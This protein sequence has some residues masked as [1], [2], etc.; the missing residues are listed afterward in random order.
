MNLNKWMILALMLTLTGCT[1]EKSNEPF[2]DLFN[3]T[4]LEGWHILGGKATYEVKDGT[5]VG[6]SVLNTSNTF[7]CSDKLYSDFILE[8]EYKVDPKLNSGIQIRTNSIPEYKNGRVH[9][10]QIEIDPSDRAWSAGIYEEGRRGWLNNLLEN[11]N[12]QKAFKQNDWNLYRIEAVGDTL[13]TWINGVPAAHL[14]DDMT[15]KGFIGLQVHGIGKSKEKEG[16]QVSWRAVRIITEEVEKYTTP[17]PVKAKIT[18]NQLLDG[19]KDKGW[20]MMWDGESTAGWRGAKLDHFPKSGWKIE[21]GALTVLASGGGES[22]AGGDIVSMEKY[23]NFE[24]KLDFKITE[25]ANSGIKY[26]VNTDLNQGKGSSIGLEFQILDD[27]KHPR[28][29]MI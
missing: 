8:V 21:N 26:Y 27:A 1:S 7:L 18:R 29:Y 17:S 22:E 5:I 4:S 12:A 23:S 16:T 25:G 2:V 15:S 10:Y 11:P 6:T 20:K 28:L 3:G 13:K 14:I 24:L 19:E 9:G